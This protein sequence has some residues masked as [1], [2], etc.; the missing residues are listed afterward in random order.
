MSDKVTIEEL[1]ARIEAVKEEN[2]EL[3]ARIEDLKKT[4]REHVRHIGR[5]ALE[6]DKARELNAQHW[7]RAERYTKEL[8]DIAARFPVARN[9][10]D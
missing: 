6:R 7:E 8:E 4:N 2:R 5:I 3:E 1:E 10:Q 9:A